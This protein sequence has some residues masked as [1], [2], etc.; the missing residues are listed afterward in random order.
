[1][2]LIKYIKKV[3]SDQKEGKYSNIYIL[4]DIHNTILVP[5]FDQEENYIY[6]PYAQKVLELLSSNPNVKLILWSST[7]QDKIQN[8][9]D[10]FIKNGIVFDY[11]NQNPEIANSSFGCFDHKFFFDIG[12]D[13][14]F[15][16]DPN[17]DWKKIYNFLV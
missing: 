4:I 17:H 15:G 13:D 12:I 10:N 1:M 6:Y 3:F 9:I 7:Y 14:K 11:I 2:S 8:Y 16:F 5:S